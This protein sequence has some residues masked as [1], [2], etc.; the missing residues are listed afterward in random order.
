MSNLT[1]RSLILAALLLI[2]VC[3]QAGMGPPPQAAAARWPANDELYR[4]VP[5]SAGALAT[6][7]P[8]GYPFV[9]RPYT[10][11]DGTAAT[12]VVVTSPRV[13]DAYRAGAAVPFLG[14]GYSVEAAPPDLTPTDS[15]VHALVVAKGDERDLLLYAY[16]ERR[17]LVGNGPLGW[18]LA[19][20]DG[21][22]WR[23]NDYYRLLLIAPYPRAGQPE[24]RE[25]VALAEALFPRIAAWYGSA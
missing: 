4:V 20:F 16:G 12:L 2:G 1:R 5:W 17:G 25:A 6:E 24:L 7:A 11:P 9:T 13:K 3:L 22:A 18:G 19:V 15:G 21:L 23:Q 8:Y 14:N 10:L